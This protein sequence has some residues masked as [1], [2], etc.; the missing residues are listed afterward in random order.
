MEQIQN[1]LTQLYQKDRLPH[2][3]LLSSPDIGL[4][5]QP[6]T[7]F[8]QWLL[9]EK[10]SACGHCHACQLFAA[11]S[12]PDYRHIQPEGKSGSIR[13]ESIRHLT[14]FLH[15]KAAIDKFRVVLIEQCD[16]MNRYAS[17]A[18]LKSLEEPGNDSILLLTA[19]NHQSLLPTILSRCQLI[20]QP[21]LMGQPIDESIV[22]ALLSSACLSDV[23]E[24]F[25]D[26]PDHFLKQCQ[27][28]LA[29]VIRVQQLSATASDGVSDKVNSLSKQL[30]LLAVFDLLDKCHQLRAALAHKISLNPVLLI[31]DLLVDCRQ[32]SKGEVHALAFEPA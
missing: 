24:K 31:E 15:E 28:I 1:Y 30:P 27:L 4:V 16:N 20:Y 10:R 9:C 32:L 25:K 2:A 29:A 14:D 26:H 6:A 8:A 18:L 12:H 11:S 13:I 5:T 23:A 19:K 21:E 17:N 7:W 22:E 3:I